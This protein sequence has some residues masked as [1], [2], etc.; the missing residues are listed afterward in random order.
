MKELKRWHIRKK[1]MMRELNRKLRRKKYNEIAKKGAKKKKKIMHELKRKL[2]S[3]R[4]DEVAK[5]GTK[6]KEI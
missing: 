1:Y 6:K 4:Y 2:R 3:K 5:K